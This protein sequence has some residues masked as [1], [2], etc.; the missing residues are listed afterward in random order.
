[1]HGTMS[2]KFTLMILYEGESNENLKIF[3]VFICLSLVYMKILSVLQVLIQSLSL[4]RENFIEKLVT[5]N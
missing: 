3:Q 5:A 2:L 4:A 1:M